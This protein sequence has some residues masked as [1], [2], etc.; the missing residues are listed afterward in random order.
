MDSTEVLFAGY[1]FS[2]VG[3]DFPHP[4]PSNSLDKSN[5][6]EREMKSNAFSATSCCLSEADLLFSQESD[7]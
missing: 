7:A 2:A 5:T 4:G 1:R 3:D 6:G